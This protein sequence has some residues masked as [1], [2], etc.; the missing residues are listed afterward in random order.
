MLQ[1]SIG[2][3]TIYVSVS[4]N[5]SKLFYV[6][7]NKNN[8]CQ[9]PAKHNNGS[10]CSS[11]FNNGCQFPAMLY[12]NDCQFPARLTIFFTISSHGIQKEREI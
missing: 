8:D 2:Q 10:H 12:K 11:I 1:V 9:C 4:S 5:I 7:T 6:S 3:T